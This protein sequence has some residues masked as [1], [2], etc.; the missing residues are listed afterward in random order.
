MRKEA[1]GSEVADLSEVGEKVQG[2]RRCVR[3]DERKQRGA[4]QREEERAEVSKQLWNSTAG[5][6]GLSVQCH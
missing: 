1:A 3:I 5:A 4:V 2:G 6:P